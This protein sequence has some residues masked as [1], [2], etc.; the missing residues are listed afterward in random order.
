MS[1]ILKRENIKPPERQSAFCCS[2]QKKKKISL[3]TEPFVLCFNKQRSPLQGDEG[4]GQR[5][6]I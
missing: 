4:S 1:F 6:Q 3:M 2:D 5:G